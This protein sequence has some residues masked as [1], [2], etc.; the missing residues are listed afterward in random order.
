L[1]LDFGLSTLFATSEGDLLGRDWLK[2][3]KRY[4]ALISMI[5]ASQQRAGRKPRD[6][7]RYR[8][9]VEDVRGFIRTE[10][11]RVLNRLVAAK[12]PAALV[13]ERLDFR[14]SDLSPRLNRL[15]QNCGRSIIQDKLRDLEERF[16]ITSTEVN[17][18]YTSQTCSCCGY[19]DKRNRRDQKTFLCL[20]C[21][22]KLHADLNA[23]A[24]IEARRARPN[25]WLFQGKDAILAELVR[26]FGERR[27]RALRSGRT[28][29]TGRDADRGCSADPRLTNPYFGRIRPVTV[30]TSPIPPALAAA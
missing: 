7:R 27:V 14:H 15:L 18:A 23:A 4:D 10:V 19:V 16:G 28:G 8:A 13:L 3:L 12:R 9:L 29:A 20:W 6:S 30:R 11:G 24:N 26:E 21:G 5:A 25:G 2:R 22:H 1:A 17:A